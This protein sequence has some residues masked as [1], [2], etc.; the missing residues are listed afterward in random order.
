[1]NGPPIGVQ[2]PSANNLA[3]EPF[4]FGPAQRRLFGCWQHPPAAERACTVLICP[5]TGPEYIRAHRT[6]RQLA[7]RLGRLGF[8]T[9]RFDYYG[10]G[11]SAGDF[12]ESSIAGWRGDIGAA[13]DEILRR[14]GTG[15]LL[16][17]GLH[18]GADMALETAARRGDIDGVL[19]WNPV[20]SG[21]DYARA[22]RQWQAQ[23]IAAGAI[24]APPPHDETP[25][26][27][28]ILGYAYTPQLM[29]E[30]E[31]H[32]LGP[33][34]RPP[35]RRVMVLDTNAQPQYVPLKTA[36]EAAGCSVQLRHEPNPAVWVLEPYQAVIP[37]QVMQILVSW[38][39][40][41]YR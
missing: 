35:A 19:L 8:R 38:I 10:T 21:A 36:L 32:S 6:L 41:V 34:T 30:L 26:C 1:M 2:P 15:S 24:P 20:G 39:A 28:E 25:S 22:L 37:H 14:F 7:L 23:S 33:W 9:L 17:L 40:E 11:D 18:L 5:P 3:V 4:Y 29:S 13:V 31:G 12:T 27:T 16:L